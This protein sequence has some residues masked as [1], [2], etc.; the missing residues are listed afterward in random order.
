MEKQRKMWDLADR[1][2]VCTILDSWQ[3]TG[4]FHCCTTIEGVFINIQTILTRSQLPL[5]VF[6]HVTLCVDCFVA[7]DCFCYCWLQSDLPHRDN[8]DSLNLEPYL[9][10]VGM[11]AG[12]GPV[13]GGGNPGGGT[14]IGNPK[15]KEDKINPLKTF[16]VGPS[17]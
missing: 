16:K 4:L 3:I 14:V 2:Y 17:G 12:G 15:T 11:I 6:S 10:M 9:S 13:G 5:D 7:V 1:L 8:K